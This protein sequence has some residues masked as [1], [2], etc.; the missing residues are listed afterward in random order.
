MNKTGKGNSRFDIIIKQF[1]PEKG[2]GISSQ[3]IQKEI[4][5]SKGRRKK[6]VLLGGAPHKGVS[7][8]PSPV[9]VKVPLFCGK[10]FICLESPDTEK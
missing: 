8:P 4:A 1:H 7:P 10:F 3:Y 2:I 6:V 9:V 5:K